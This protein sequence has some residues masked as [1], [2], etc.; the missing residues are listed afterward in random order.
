[1]LIAANA[2]VAEEHRALKI[3][4]INAA[5]PKAPADMG[6]PVVAPPQGGALPS[7]GAGAAP[8]PKGKGALFAGIG[9][10]VVLLALVVGV[11]IHLSHGDSHDKSHAAAAPHD[12]KH[13]KH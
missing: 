4:E 9:A 1:M 10:I 13:G 2:A 12:A 7:A 3:A 8:A 11:A 5:Q 6:V